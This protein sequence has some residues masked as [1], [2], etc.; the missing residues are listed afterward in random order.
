MVESLKQI[1]LPEYAMQ[2]EVYA[3]SIY[4]KT[5]ESVRIIQSVGVKSRT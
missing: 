1:T 4:N 3:N 2:I 5:I